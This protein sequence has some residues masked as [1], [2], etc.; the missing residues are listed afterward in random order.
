[1]EKAKCIIVVDDDLAIQDAV[2]VM[3]ERKGFRVVAYED[4][5][6]LLKDNYEIPDLFILDKQLP[7]IDGL[8]ICRWLK[9][10]ELTRSVPVLMLSASP[11]I[12]KLAKEACADDFL[13]KPFKMAAL[14]EAV[15]RLTSVSSK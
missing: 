11:H 7:G 1:M 9:K 3:L 2:R 12:G 10:Q 15:D 4:G 13:E 14:R 8:E 6:P 5:D